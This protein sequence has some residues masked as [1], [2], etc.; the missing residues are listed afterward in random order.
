MNRNQRFQNE[1]CIAEFIQ[2]VGEYSHCSV[3]KLNGRYIYLEDRK[4]S[5]G[6]YL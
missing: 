5:K 4:D 1:D 2:Y 3:T 6:T